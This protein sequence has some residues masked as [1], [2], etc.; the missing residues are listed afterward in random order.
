[1]GI[2]NPTEKSIKIHT[3]TAKTHPNLS[4]S[5]RNLPVISKRLS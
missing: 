2:S 1:M 4:V 3:K 5:I